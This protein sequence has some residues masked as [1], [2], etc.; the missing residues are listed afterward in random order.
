M[1]NGAEALELLRLCRFI[2]EILGK[3]RY[4]NLKL[5][6]FFSRF[7]KFDLRNG[8]GDGCILIKFMSFAKFAK[9]DL[10][11][12]VVGEWIKFKTAPNL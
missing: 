6:R 10:Q 7:V 4:A 1:S 3:K 2:R 9:F 12:A 11:V 8:R 5:C